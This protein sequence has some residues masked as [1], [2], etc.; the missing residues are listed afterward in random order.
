[1]RSHIGKHHIKPIR[2]EVSFGRLNE[3]WPARIR[4]H[5][6]HFATLIDR[7]TSGSIGAA[8]HGAAILEAN[9]KAHMFGITNIKCSGGTRRLCFRLTGTHREDQ[10]QCIPTI[11][12]PRFGNLCGTKNRICRRWLR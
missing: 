3:S 5:R 6:Q 1:M 9:V 12:R 7:P 4:G 11:A 10:F 8:G 2:Q